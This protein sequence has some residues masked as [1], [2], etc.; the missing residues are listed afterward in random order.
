LMTG[1]LT[2]GLV[3]LGGS[4][5]RQAY[6]KSV[7][8]AVK[9]PL[10]GWGDPLWDLTSWSPTFNWVISVYSRPLEDNASQESTLL[11]TSFLL[12]VFAGQEQQPLITFQPAR[13]TDVLYYS[14][15]FWS[16]SGKQVLIRGE[17]LGDETLWQ[18]PEGKQSGTLQTR[19]GYY[20]WISDWS[21]WSPDSTR[22][23]GTLSA[24]S[25]AQEP[26]TLLA[27][28]HATDG[29]LLSA[30]PSALKEITGPL[31]WSPDGERLAGRG[32]TD[33]QLAIWR[34]A[35]GA[36]LS[37][38]TFPSEIAGFTWSPSGKYIALTM[39]NSSSWGEKEDGHL[40]IWEVSTNRAV[41]EIGASIGTDVFSL[42][43]PIWSPDGAF[44]VFTD[45]GTPCVLKTRGSGDFF[46]VGTNTT[47]AFAWSPNGK[48]LALARAGALNEVEVWRVADRTLVDTFP[49]QYD[50]SDL[51]RFGWSADGRRI[52]AGSKHRQIQS[53]QVR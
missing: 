13:K 27:I 49:F 15:L 33:Q 44:L 4:V 1:A 30:H 22:L 25:N 45:G 35:D 17:D 47:Y 48:F 20:S 14:S 40:I 3:L 41:R 19:D 34:V 24:F 10:A 12:A 50:F 31:A 18:I 2:G 39:G 8:P 42:R 37:T 46:Y 36:L 38:H 43:S 16:P 53:W 9:G 28:W 11:D 21:A 5:L 51:Q 32:E 52:S 7:S 6:Q 26:D 23:A 29:R